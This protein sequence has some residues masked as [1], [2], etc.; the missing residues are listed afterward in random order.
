MNKHHRTMLQRRV[1]AA[2]AAE[3]A[4]TE[5]PA[6]TAAVAATRTDP[7]WPRLAFSTQ[8]ARAILRTSSERRY[9]AKDRETR[10]QYRKK[11]RAHATTK[12]REREK[13]REKERE[14]TKKNIWKTSRLCA[15]RARASER[16][17]ERKCAPNVS[18]S[19]K[20]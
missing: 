6:P 2:T 3:T 15:G 8:A 20:I 1:P 13:K 7:Q 4:I 10:R 14:N 16:K 17:K 18:F 12:R 11:T 9:R 5:V 19:F